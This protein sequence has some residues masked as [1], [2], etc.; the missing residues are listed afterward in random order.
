M[1]IAPEDR[2]VEVG[3]RTVVIVLVPI[4]VAAASP[5]L[6]LMG[7]PQAAM[8][9]SPSSEHVSR[10]SAAAH[11]VAMVKAI[12]AADAPTTVRHMDS[13]LGCI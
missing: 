5:G 3:D 9:S 1:D 4:G 13:M 2:L 10:S 8:A 11:M 12:N 6:Q 7:W